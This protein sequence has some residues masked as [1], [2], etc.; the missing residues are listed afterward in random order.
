[1]KEKIKYLNP[2]QIIGN[3]LIIIS[4]LGIFI[5]KQNVQDIMIKLYWLSIMLNIFGII[6]FLSTWTKGGI[7]AD[8]HSSKRILQEFDNI[9]LTFLCCYVLV[10]LGMAFYFNI[11]QTGRDNIYVIISFFLFT[12]FA[13]IIVYISEEK[14]YKETIKLVKKNKIGKN[15]K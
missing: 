4:F 13:E 8:V 7:N 3:I 14:A 10:F 2:I 6:L 12:M 5:T 1:M 9:S 11:T 15:K